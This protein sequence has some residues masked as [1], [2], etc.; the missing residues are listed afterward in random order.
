MH[1]SSVLHRGAGSHVT[2]ETIVPMEMPWV[3]IAEPSSPPSTVD[4]AVWGGFPWISSISESLQL[5]ITQGY[6]TE[7]HIIESRPPG[8]CGCRWSRC[9]L[10]VFE[11]AVIRNGLV[12]EQVSLLLGMLLMQCSAS[13]GRVEGLWA[14]GIELRMK[15][16]QKEGGG[17]GGGEPGGDHVFLC[18]FGC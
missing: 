4:Q 12:K 15:K 7:N 9:I 2:S 18:H 13:T 1:C 6:V 14:D 3:K 5:F 17:G 11:V 16:T 8:G 10:A